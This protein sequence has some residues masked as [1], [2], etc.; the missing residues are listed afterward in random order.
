MDLA[1]ESYD[2]QEIHEIIKSHSVTT[3]IRMKE[4]GEDN[5]LFSRLGQ[6]DKF[7][8]NEADLQKYL[9]KPMRFTGAAE[10]QTE[11]YLRDVVKP[12]VER[13]KEFIGT[14]NSKINV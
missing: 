2:R 1:K 7:P 10:I 9:D 4:E 3:G 6:D 5:D 11:E 8:L 12:L 13:N 14:I